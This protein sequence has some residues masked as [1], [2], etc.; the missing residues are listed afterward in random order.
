MKRL[1]PPL[2]ASN[3]RMLPDTA[4]AAAA[5]EKEQ[6]V[7]PVTLIVG[8]AIAAAAFLRKKAAQAA[9]IVID[10][11]KVEIFRSTLPRAAQ[12][13]AEIVL[14]V[15][16]EQGVDPLLIV[17]LVQR[18]D[19]K[20]DPNIVTFDGGHGLTQITSDKAWLARMGARA[21]DPYENLTHGVEMLKDNLRYFANKGLT[22]ADQLRAALAAYNHGPG[23]VWADVRAGRDPD[24]GTTGGDYSA[25]VTNTLASLTTSF[26]NAVSYAEATGQ[27]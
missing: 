2:V 1:V 16:S 25:D 7:E 15:A 20:W 23:S 24:T 11:A 19:P 27:V 14:K 10:A 18:E 4:A 13:Y 6:P 12:P 22:G 21:F 17:A 9:G 5:N 26:Q 8:G 3:K